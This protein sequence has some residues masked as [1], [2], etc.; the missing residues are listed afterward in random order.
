MNVE[1]T[2]NS[3]KCR[4]TARNLLTEVSRLVSKAGK[5]YDSRMRHEL[6]LEAMSMSNE[7]YNLLGEAR[8]LSGDMHSVGH[9]IK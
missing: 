7:A 6:Y 2:R 3:D 5:T 4:K 8:K 1:E 9:K